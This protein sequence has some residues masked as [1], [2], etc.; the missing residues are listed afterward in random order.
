MEKN[1][2]KI[3][4]CFILL[5]SVLTGCEQAETERK[6]THAEEVTRRAQ[7]AE[8]EKIESAAHHSNATWYLV[9]I[10]KYNGQC[11]TLDSP[12]TPTE[13]LDLWTA[14][15]GRALLEARM[16]GQDYILKYGVATPSQ[17]Y[18]FVTSM[19]LCESIIKMNTK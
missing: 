8:L 13:Y 12:K 15:R 10:S 2:L 9:K 16:E 7:D 17:E 18:I 3:V 6:P 4:S 1:L 19:E 14:R 11:D 5:T